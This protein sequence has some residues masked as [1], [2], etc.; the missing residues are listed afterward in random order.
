[1]IS[2]VPLSGYHNFIKRDVIGIFYHMVSDRIVPHTE[3]LYPHRDINPFEQD[4]V[5]EKKNSQV[6]NFDD[7]LTSRTLNQRKLT[8]GIFISL[9][10]VFQNV[11]PWSDHC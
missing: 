4:L 9:M 2:K 8:P 5:Y 1:M 3:H 10:M 6:L 11:F 7:L